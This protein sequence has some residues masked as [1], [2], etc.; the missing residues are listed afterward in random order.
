[1]KIEQS[2]KFCVSVINDN[3][4]RIES[5]SAEANIL[6]MMLKKLEEIRCGLIDIEDKIDNSESKYLNKVA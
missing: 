6:F 1:M 4:G 5:F 3:G 2:Q